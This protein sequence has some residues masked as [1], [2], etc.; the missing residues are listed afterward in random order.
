MCGIAAILRLGGGTPDMR[1]LARMTDAI[2][3]RG[4]DDSG[5]FADGPLAFGFRRLSILDLSP[6]GHQPMT[7]PGGEVTI[8]FNG[9]IYNFIELRR[10]LEAKGH[11]FLSSGDTEVLLHAYLEW[12]QACLDRLNGMFAFLIY[13]ARTRTVFGARDR[14]GVKPMFLYRDGAHLLF[15]SE[16]K[17]IRASGLCR[18]NAPNWRVAADYLLQDQLDTTTESFFAGIEQVAPGSAFTVALDGAMRSWRFW[19]VDSDRASPT[20]DPIGRFAELFEDS[21]RLRMRSD[22]PV[23]VCLSG[24]LDSTSIICAM[25]R[26]AADAPSLNAFCFVDAEFDE[27]RYLDDT[28]AQT[29]AA[30]HYVQIRDD[31]IWDRLARLQVVQDEPVQSLTPLIGWELMKLAADNGVKVVLNG[32][33]ADEILA[34]YSSYFRVYWQSLMQRG[35]W[36]KAHREIEAFAA[37]HGE[38]SAPLVRR[39]RTMLLRSVLGRLPFYRSLAVRHNLRR[40]RSHRW[41]RPELTR[42]ASYRWH[43]ASGGSLFE[44]LKR[45]VEHDALPLYLRIEDRNSMA[46]SVEARLPFMD[47]RLVAQAFGMDDDLKLRG[48][49]NKHALREAMRGK[50]PE[51]V[52]T[53][54]DKMG[55]PIPQRR[56]VAGTLYE[57]IRDLLGSGS[58]REQGLYDVEAILGDLERHRRGEIDI[59]LEILRVCQMELWRNDV[60]ARPA[61]AARPT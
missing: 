11:R 6:A 35:R 49:W 7:T 40:L 61:A 25:A 20:S 27:T 1:A 24:G 36:A 16:I 47:Y 38:V 53:R 2:A 10:E 41:F 12:G 14:L 5:T 48:P 21:V 51:S 31:H 26:A 34:G 55:F 9:E 42:H 13:D 44:A 17:A 28:L 37:T 58:V 45:S 59:A 22:V 43:G 60:L 32:Q 56:W 54:V 3:H 4:P 39:Q 19:S 50:I 15:A 23:G 8:I 30:P 18:A 33:G 57:P 46:H 52:R 29:R